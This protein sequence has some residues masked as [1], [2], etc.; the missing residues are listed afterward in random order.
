MPLISDDELRRAIGPKW[1]SQPPPEPEPVDISR[2][3]E[4]FSEAVT[5]ARPAIVDA[6]IELAAE[7]ESIKSSIAEVFESLRTLQEKK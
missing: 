7:V 1:C 3:A 4:A 2:F 6:F 5:K